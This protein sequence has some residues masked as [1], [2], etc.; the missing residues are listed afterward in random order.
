MLKHGF[1]EP[2]PEMAIKGNLTLNPRQ[3]QKPQKE[4]E[5]G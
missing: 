3:L 5:N 4:Y 1:M 2:F